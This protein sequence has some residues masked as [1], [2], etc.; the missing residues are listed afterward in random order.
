M[1]ISSP[2]FVSRLVV[3]GENQAVRDLLRIAGAGCSYTVAELQALMEEAGWGDC[4]PRVWPF[5][6]KDEVID[7]QFLQVWIRYLL[8]LEPGKVTAWMLRTGHGT[9]LSE[10]E[11]PGEVVVRWTALWDRQPTHHRLQAEI[12]RLNSQIVSISKE[13]E[14]K[15][16]KLR[17]AI[18]MMGQEKVVLM[19]EIL[20]LNQRLR[21][22]NKL[23]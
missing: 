4:F 19:E 7:K 5:P 21:E 14:M 15:M 18:E 12:D 17:S 22:L 16:R 2:A 8:E 13:V 1:D 10:S 20:V 11:P 9:S 6:N 23:T 3:N